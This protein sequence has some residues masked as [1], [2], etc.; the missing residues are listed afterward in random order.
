MDASPGK[1]QFLSGELLFFLQ[2]PT[3]KQGILSDCE[4]LL[5]FR[6]CG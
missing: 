6:V 1:L 2:I 4:E 3:R 5:E